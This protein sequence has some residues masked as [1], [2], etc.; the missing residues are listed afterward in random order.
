MQDF[1]RLV[2][3]RLAFDLGKEIYRVVKDFPDDELYGLI[4]QMRRCSISVASNISEGCGRNTNKGFCSFLYIAMGSLKELE[5]QIMFSR[6]F[7]YLNE[8]NFLLIV[9]KIEF[10]E[11]KLM[12]LIRKV[13][14]S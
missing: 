13:R 4:S 8:A 11:I 10:L 12:N 5:T 9:G 1:K 7:D 6:D 2:V 14:G 3:W